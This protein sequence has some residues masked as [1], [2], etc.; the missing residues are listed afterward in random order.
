MKLIV[1]GSYL[2]YANYLHVNRLSRRDAKYAS[3][4]DQIR[5]LGKEVEVIKYGEWWLSPCVDEL[6]ELHLL[7]VEETND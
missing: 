5:G 3:S 2:Q 4:P 6:C 7:Q 1:S